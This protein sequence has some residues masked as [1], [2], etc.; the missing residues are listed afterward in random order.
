[1]KVYTEAEFNQIHIE[2]LL[3]EQINSNLY[4]F[5][6]IIVYENQ[7]QKQQFWYADFPSNIDIVVSDSQICTDINLAVEHDSH[8]YLTAKF[9]LSGYHNVICPG[10]KGIAAEYAETGGHSYLF[11]LP[12][13]EEIEQSWT[14]DRL[15]RLKIEID[16]DFLDRFVTELNTVPKQLQAL[17]EDNNPRRFHFTVG[18]ITSGMQTVIGQICHHPYQGEIA[19]MYLEAKV[20][21][22]LAMQLTQLAE[23]N[24][25]RVKPTLKS[26]NIDRIYQARDI[27]TNRLEYPPSVT[28]LARQVN[29][30]ESTLRRGFRELFD[31]TVISY[32]TQKRLEQA[33]RLLREGKLTI[34]EIASLVG[35]SHLSYFAAA[36]KR[37]FGI[38]PRECLAGKLCQLDKK[39]K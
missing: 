31:T 10:I 33:K 15:K 11:Y 34:S 6:E 4:G 13:I 20:M 39:K 26:Q 27:L 22:L 24:L 14:G 36:F 2:S 38:T 3:S 9:Y 1:M 30:S 7:L 16:L 32:L 8:Q 29:I 19:R 23:S 25:N 18:K 21:E 37:Q 5:D 17:V 35:Y 12:D 28:E